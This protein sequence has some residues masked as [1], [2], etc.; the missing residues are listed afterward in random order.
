MSVHF[1]P[2]PTPWPTGAP[3][4]AMPTMVGQLPVVSAVRSDVGNDPADS[5]E[6]VVIAHD[7]GTVEA[8][9]GPRWVVA[10]LLVR[11]GGAVTTTVLAAESSYTD[12]LA[13]QLRHA[14]PIRASTTW[15]AP[16]GVAIDPHVV[17][18]VM[19]ALYEACDD[20]WLAL[21]DDLLIRARLARRCPG[22][23]AI[24]PTD[25]RCPACA[26]DTPPG[27][28][29]PF[30]AYRSE[31]EVC[32]HLPDDDSGDDSGELRL[33]IAVAGG[34]TVGRAYADCRWLYGLWRDDRLL[35]AGSDLRSGSIGKT[36]QQMARV[37]V[38]HLLA[39]LLD[40]PVDHRD[41]GLGPVLRGRLVRW[42]DEH[43]TDV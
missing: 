7:S 33:G 30:G 16:H 39:R 34:G 6:F 25:E 4:V 42:R 31:P 32:W 9:D 41:R 3:W 21:L 14:G 29:N 27:P 2:G 12:A 22:C 18:H 8:Q 11:R 28:A 35:V 1:T 17:H 19:V 24:L 26:T 13:V 10:Q 38:D 36:H 5:A 37:L 40:A 43:T 20:Q 15:V 23:A